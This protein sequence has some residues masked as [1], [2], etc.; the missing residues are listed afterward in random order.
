MERFEGLAQH[1]GEAARIFIGIIAAIGVL[2]GLLAAVP[3]IV[4]VAGVSGIVGAA[5]FMF[6]QWVRSQVNE[7]LALSRSATYHLAPN[8]HEHELP[9]H[10]RD[11]PMRAVVGLG[12]AECYREQALLRSD[13]TRHEGSAMYHR[14]TV[15]PTEGT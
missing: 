10:L 2:L 3:L 8:G 14:E 12:L 11:K 13:F 4:V 5:G 6:M 9:E 7:L 15:A 1:V